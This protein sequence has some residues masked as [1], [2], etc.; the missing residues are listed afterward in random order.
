MFGSRQQADLLVELE[1]LRAQVAD[2]ESERARGVRLDPTTG[3]LTL[4]S[5]R[6]RLTEEAMRASRYQRPLSVAILAV[7]DFDVIEIRR[8]F[9]A[10]DELL[11]AL[12]TRLAEGIRSHDLV[13]RTGS[14]ELGI[15]LPD[16]RAEDARDTLERLIGELEKSGESI[17]SGVSVS[18]G[19]AGLEREMSPEALLAGARI[20]CHRAQGAGGG[21]AALASE[22]QTLK[23]ASRGP[24]EA[25]EALAVALTE[26]DR[27]TGEHSEAVI[28]MSVAV[29]RHLGLREAEVERVRSAALL[30]DI[31][32]VAIPDEILRKPGPLTESEWA[33]MREHPVIGERI[34][35]VLPGMSGVARIVRHE[36][37]RWDGGGY[38]DGLAGEEIPL[39]SR[40]IIAADTYHAI[41]S[42]RPYRARRS[43][44][45]A[46][47]ELTR[48]AGTQFDPTVTASLV[49][50][51]YGQRQ[52]GAVAV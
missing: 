43:H 1:R 20:A 39:G 48:C 31:G 27:Y 51:L 21:Q 42:D 25:V 34:L 3:L 19:I 2:L 5:F 28:E 17:V 38:P 6:G 50:Y 33:L 16:M 52:A 30:H 29:A 23:N 4:R 18:M 8:G 35:S 47:D 12:A 7:E 15:L 46:I 24:R 10:A 32:K 26:R 36:H 14:D 37:E 11:V 44:A 41:T 40:I 22:Q 9:K 45:E 13:G 49:G